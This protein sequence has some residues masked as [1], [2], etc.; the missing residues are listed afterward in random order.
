MQRNEKEEGCWGLGK[1]R[2]W[3]EVPCG[4][5]CDSRKGVQTHFADLVNNPCRV[6]AGPARNGSEPAGGFLFPLSRFKAPAPPGRLPLR[7]LEPPGT[8]AAPPRADSRDRGRGASPRLLPGA[9]P[10]PSPL[11]PGSALQRTGNPR[12]PTVKSQR[13]RGNLLRGS[14]PTHAAGSWARRGEPGVPQVAS[15]SSGAQPGQ[16]AEGALAGPTPTRSATSQ[17]CAG[18]HERRFKNKQVPENQTTGGKRLDRLCLQ[19]LFPRTS[20]RGSIPSPLLRP[21]ALRRRELGAGRRGA[22]G[23]VHVCAPRPDLGPSGRAA[24]TASRLR[25]SGPGCCP[26]P[27]LPLVATVPAA[28]LPAPGRSR[29]APAVQPG[30]SGDGWKPE[31]QQLTVGRNSPLLLRS[32]F[33]S[34]RPKSE[35]TSPVIPASLPPGAV[36]CAARARVGACAVFALEIKTSQRIMVRT[37]KTRLKAVCKRRDPFPPLQPSF[38]SPVS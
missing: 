28:E 17:R 24:G 15:L 11:L 10:A 31:R 32:L 38:Q 2:G 9:F 19:G 23:R 18:T 6:D 12:L 30:Q 22:L 27:S 14:T 1:G 25:G 16:G 13:R 5:Y 36:T 8:C 20:S 35:G 26:P 33:P 3:E 21:G 7:Y 4:R 29:G 34:V 37:F